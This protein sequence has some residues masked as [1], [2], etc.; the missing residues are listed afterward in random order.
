MAGR[1][2][3][4]RD[5]RRDSA[6]KRGAQRARKREQAQ[7]RE[8]ERSS[9]REERGEREE[10]DK[11]K[12]REERD[13]RAHSERPAAV[14]RLSH[15]C[16]IRVASLS[17]PSLIPLSSLDRTS[18]GWATTAHAPH[19]KSRAHLVEFE[20]RVAVRPELERERVVRDLA[21]YVRGRGGARVRLSARSE[22]GERLRTRHTHITRQHRLSS[23][24]RRLASQWSRRTRSVR[25]SDSVRTTHT[26]SSHVIARLVEV[27]V[28][29]PHRHDRACATVRRHRRAASP[30]V[31]A[32]SSSPRRCPNAGARATNVH[33]E[34]KGKEVGCCGDHRG[35]RRGWRW[36]AAATLV[37]GG[38]AANGG[39]GGSAR[40]RRSGGAREA[41]RARGEGRGATDPRARRSGACRAAQHTE[42]MATVCRMDQDRGSRPLRCNRRAAAR[43]TARRAMSRHV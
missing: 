18:I 31:R 32:S 17:H 15:P 16:R 2:V 24:P 6:W 9:E 23:S 3:V 34:G 38:K 40:G 10:R 21:P 26:P 4:E 35:G 29:G 33:A 30:V 14:R 37:E 20:G 25:G 43:R 13:Q 39:G 27:V 1:C 41:T 28:L 5:E 12:R 42:E 7:A 19:A 11:R 22:C 36:G 8:K